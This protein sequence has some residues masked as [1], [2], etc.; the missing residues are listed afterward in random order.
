M[1]LLLDENLPKKLKTVLKEHEV[2]TVSDKKWNS[3]K[4]GELLRLM[5]E[6]NFNAFLTFD[7]NLQYQQN[8]LKYPILVLVLVASD[9]TL[10]TLQHL[11]EKINSALENA[12]GK[13]VMIINYNQ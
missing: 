11:E 10:E 5:L 13:G 12:N 7:R 3:Y 8:F 2:Y 6:E 4:N 1:K 9:N